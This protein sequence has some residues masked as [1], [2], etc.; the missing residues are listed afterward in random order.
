[1]TEEKV[2]LNE[3]DERDQ[4]IEWCLLK[5]E[6]RPPQLMGFPMT[7]QLDELPNEQ[8]EGE[9]IPRMI[10]VVTIQKPDN[11][12]RHYDWANSQDYSSTKTQQEEDGH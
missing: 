3:R 1:M 8:I 12:N 10:G 9:E 7:D 4:E 11:R 5:N 6:S 2:I